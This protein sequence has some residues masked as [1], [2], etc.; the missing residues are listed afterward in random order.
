MEFFIS[1]QQLRVILHESNRAN[2][3]QPMKEMYSFMNNILQIVKKKYGLNLKLL[4]TWGASVGG[5]VL[6]LNEFIKTGDFILT[7]EQRALIL[8]GLASVVFYDNKR[9]F[10]KVYS[11]IKQEGLVEAFESA[12]K[13]TLKLKNVF[14]R[15]MKSLNVSISSI[16]ELLSYA[17]IIPII[18][19]IQELTKSGNLE[20]IANQIASRL[21][22][23]GVVLI[24][25][26]SL[27]EVIKKILD[28]IK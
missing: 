5:L 27:K 9:A 14:I 18:S 3:S 12:M 11:K 25:S 4:L 23:S 19:D 10:N 21:F 20:E 13:K 15:F 1:E 16:S 6:P 28:R 7:D 2:F 22:A 17:F 8:V 24:S 26:E